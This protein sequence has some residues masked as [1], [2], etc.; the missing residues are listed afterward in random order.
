[1][2]LRRLI[3]LNHLELASDDVVV[4][5]TG[6]GF[7]VGKGERGGLTMVAIGTSG[8]KCFWTIGHRGLNSSS[9]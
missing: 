9:V 1:M 2:E 5:G 7:V 6:A 4:Q 8:V 3:I